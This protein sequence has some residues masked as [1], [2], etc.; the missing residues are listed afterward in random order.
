MTQE[1]DRMLTLLQ[2]LAALKEIEER[3]DSVDASEHR[4]R[5]IQI[6]NEMK[7]L[8]SEKKGAADS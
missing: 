3:G 8:A 7:R 5:K 2:E 4:S 6:R 1:S